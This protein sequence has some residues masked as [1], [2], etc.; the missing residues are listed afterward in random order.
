MPEWLKWLVAGKELEELYKWRSEWEEYRRWLAEFPQVAMALD[1]MRSEING[2]ALDAC[3]PPGRNGPWTIR[4]LRDR[5][6]AMTSN[7][8]VSGAGTAAA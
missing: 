7:T 1:N 4:G 6:R 3:H 5:M 2:E 8:K